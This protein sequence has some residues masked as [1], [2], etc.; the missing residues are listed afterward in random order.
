M[1]DAATVSTPTPAVEQAAPLLRLSAVVKTFPGVRALDGVDLDVAAGEVHCLLGQN[2]AGK[3]TLIKVLAGVHRPDAGDIVWD[4]QPVTFPSPQASMRAGIATIYQELDLVDDLTVAENVFLGHEPR[5]AG[6]VHRGPGARRTREILAQLGHP[7]IPPGRLVG[8]LP[9]AAKQVVSMGRALSRRA[10]L[11][12]MDEPSAVLAHDE[13]ANLFRVI[14]GLTAGG[15]AVVYISHRLEEIR[16]IGDRVTVLK[17]GRTSAANLPAAT[18]STRELVGYMTGRSIE[19]VFPPRPPAPPVPQRP[20]EPTVS[21]GSVAAPVAPLL[22]VS[23]LGRSGE[24]ADVSLTVHS[25]EIVGIAGLVGSGRSELL[26]T[27]YG[28]RRA[29][30]GSVRLDGRVLRPGSVRA[31]VRAG[32]GM[33][34]EER[35]SQALLLG[36]PVY[37]NVTLATFGRLARAGFTDAARERAEAARVT[38]ELRLVPADVRRPVRTLSGGNQ[39]KVVLA[40]WLLRGGCAGTRLLLLDEP[41]RGVDVGARAELYGVIRRLADDGV[42]VLLVSSEVPEVLGLA[43]RVLVMREGRV[44]HEA[45]ASDLD[46][47][48]VL[49]LVMAGSLLSG[50]QAEGDLS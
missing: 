38:G 23:G 44:I 31:A 9:A 50:A 37:R 24:F 21:Q 43:D 32:I 5:T 1:D 18:T 8:K 45:A 2:G 39:Q 11:L 17:D 4:G 13:V 30:S 27:V 6:F 46:E 33:A 20:T 12:V 48:A 42:G 22:E 19:Y 47:H 35:K 41:T 28:A 49:D 26:E 7:E 25:G 14:R 16:E 36:E 15:I 34:P 10:R 40:R 3:S 29:H